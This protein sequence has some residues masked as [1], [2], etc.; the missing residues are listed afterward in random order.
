VKPT[1][2]ISATPDCA[3]ILA[4]TAFFSELAPQQLDRVSQLARIEEYPQASCIYGLGDAASD[5][6]VLVDGM[7]RFTIG[8]G[9]RQTHAGQILKRGEVFGWAAVVESAQK[10]IA[11]ALC[12]TPCTVLAM[13]GDQLLILME[14]DH[15]L[16]YRIMKQL[17]VLITGNLTAFASG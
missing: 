8:L 3:G 14:Q 9:T 15:S 2:A 5:F 17:N 7:V 16:G 13:N 11:S 1:T 12:I 6:Y 10:R 4:H